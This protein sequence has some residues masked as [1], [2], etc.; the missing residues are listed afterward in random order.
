MERRVSKIQDEVLGKDPVSEWRVAG[1][2]QPESGK[3]Q[4]H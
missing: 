2:G 3:R 4:C 1:T